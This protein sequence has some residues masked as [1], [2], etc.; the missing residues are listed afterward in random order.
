MN[1]SGMNGMLV[2]PRCTLISKHTFACPAC[3]HSPA[4]ASE[5]TKLVQFIPIQHQYH[6]KGLCHR[7]SSSDQPQ[8]GYL[9]PFR[10]PSAA[11]RPF[12]RPQGRCMAS[13][14][15]MKKREI[16]TFLSHAGGSGILVGVA[17][18]EKLPHGHFGFG[19]VQRC[20]TI[21]IPIRTIGL[22]DLTY[23]IYEWLLTQICQGVTLFMDS[24]QE[25]SCIGCT[26]EEV[27]VSLLCFLGVGGLL[28][29][30]SFVNISF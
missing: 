26:V 3:R 14:A 1:F 25:I 17:R 18:N 24:D 27:S 13:K 28:L 19:T 11:C 5:K 23:R 22:L 9:G 10:S 30:L 20:S 2:E 12:F 7:A 15:L 16:S 21:H 6:Q 8:T 29:S 4:T